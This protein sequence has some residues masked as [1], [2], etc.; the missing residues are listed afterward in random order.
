VKLV[1]HQQLLPPLDHKV[2]VGGLTTLASVRLEAA[3]VVVE[4]FLE[5]VEAGLVLAAGAAG[6]CLTAEQL[7]VLEG[8]VEQVDGL[9]A[10]QLTATEREVLFAHAVQ[11]VLLRLDPL[12]LLAARVLAL[13]ATAQQVL[14]VVCG[15]ALRALRGAALL[16]LCRRRGLSEGLLRREVGVVALEETHEIVG[17]LLDAFGE[18]GLR[19]RL[20]ELLEVAV[21]HATLALRRR[22]RCRLLLLNCTRLLCPSLPRLLVGFMFLH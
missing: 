11:L 19:H 15:A 6:A 16:T 12:R 22:T 10:F 4:D 14:E 13:V 5:N 8:D 1:C 20:L 9:Q 18:L 7:V 3:C 17:G 2:R 21:D